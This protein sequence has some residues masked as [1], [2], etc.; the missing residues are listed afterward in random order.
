MVQSFIPEGYVDV[1]EAARILKIHPMTLRRWISRQRVPG[2]IKVFGKYLIRK[3]E[4][5][6]FA[7]NYDGRIGRHRRKPWS[8]IEK[9]LPK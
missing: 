8:W 7:A 6:Q 4:L 2:V 3:V 9:A 5:E 1:L